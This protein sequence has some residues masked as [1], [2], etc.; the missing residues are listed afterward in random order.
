QQ[1]ID[2]LINSPIQAAEQQLI[3]SLIN[4]PIQIEE[5][6][7]TDCL[8]N[9]PTE[10]LLIDALANITDNTLTTVF[11]NQLGIFNPECLNTSDIFSNELC[12][13]QLISSNFPDDSQASM[14][15]SDLYYF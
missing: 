6:Q 8:I 3:N 15:F 2:S 1:F 12:N 4:S 7:F 14:D 11:N 13:N 10:Q 5:Q 9:L